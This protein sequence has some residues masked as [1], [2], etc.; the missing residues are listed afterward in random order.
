MQIGAIA[1]MH[2]VVAH[3]LLLFV[4]FIFVC[5]SFLP[6]SQLNY[7]LVLPHLAKLCEV[8]ENREQF[9]WIKD[10]T[11]KIRD[12]VQMEN[13]ICHQVRLNLISCDNNITKE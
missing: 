11:L 8:C 5:L 12:L 3:P 9:R 4:Y 1:T 13:S 10:T 7:T 6:F 2:T